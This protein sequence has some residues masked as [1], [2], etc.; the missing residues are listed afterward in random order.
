MCFLL[1]DGVCVYDGY[2]CYGDVKGCYDSLKSVKE[3]CH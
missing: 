1:K 2:K 3:S